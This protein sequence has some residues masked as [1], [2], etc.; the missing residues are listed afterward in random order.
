[1]TASPVKHR[2]ALPGPEPQPRDLAPYLTGRSGLDLVI[3]MAHDLRSPLGSILMLA[4]ELAEGQGGPVNDL[5]HRQLGLIH[6]AALCLCSAASDVVEL[7]RGDRLGELDPEPFSVGEVLTSV[8]DLVRLTAEEKGLAV[9]LEP[10][11]VDRRRGHPRALSRVLLNLTTNALKSTERGGV[12][13]AAQERGPS[14]VTFSVTDT[15]PG[16]DLQSLHTLY[17]PFRRSGTDPRYHFSGSGL[18]LTICRK[19]VAAMGAEL[20]VQTEPGRGTRFSFE[21][22]LPPADGTR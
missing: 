20:S 12:E 4:E 5:Q 21:L 2:V 17:Q 22:E 19:L 3:E 9:R 13:I 14:L 18:G 15:G 16:I 10:P 6:S 11:T 1:M 7:A 8:R